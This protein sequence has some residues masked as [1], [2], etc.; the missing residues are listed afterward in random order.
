SGENPVRLLGEASRTTC[1]RAAADEGLVARARELEQRLLGEQPR[2]AS[3]MSPERPV[4]FFCTEFAIH[5][6]LPIY[7]GGLGVLAGD[8]LKEASD[9]G[10][11]YVGIGML[12]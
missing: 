6:S 10:L 1:E 4:A 8:I 12:Y 5:R 3:S 11:P 2:A 7:S 9:R